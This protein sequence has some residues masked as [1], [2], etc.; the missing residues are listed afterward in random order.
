MPMEVNYEN[1]KALEESWSLAMDEIAT[2]K[3]KLENAQ[4][5]R[6]AYLAKSVELEEECNSYRHKEHEAAEQMRFCHKILDRIGAPRNQDNGLSYHLNGRLSRLIRNE[7][8]KL[9]EAELRKA[10][11]ERDRF[12]ALILTALK[13]NGGPIDSSDTIDFVD[14]VMVR[15]VDFEALETAIK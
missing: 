7:T 2:L 13:E 9:W 11:I 6:D 10:E 4:E 3:L 5:D 14:Y 15:R 12:R 1:M 8:G